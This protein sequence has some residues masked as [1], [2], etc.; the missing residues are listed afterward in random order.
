MLAVQGAGLSA[1]TAALVPAIILQ[2]C[3]SAA[4]RCAESSIKCQIAQSKANKGLLQAA[5]SGLRARSARS[6]ARCSDCCAGACQTEQCLPAAGR[7]AE[8]NVKCLQIAQITANRCRPQAACSGLHACRARTQRSDCAASA[9]DHATTAQRGRHARR[10]ARCSVLIVRH[11]R[12]SSL[13]G[14]CN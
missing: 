5:C 7:C 12:S 11:H 6:R 1:V 8:S 2:Q 9:C 4:G 14:G 10:P 3:L 13:P